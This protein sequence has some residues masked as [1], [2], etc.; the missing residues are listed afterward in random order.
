MIFKKYDK[1]EEKK[2][3]DYYSDY[4]IM[5]NKIIRKKREEKNPLINHINLNIYIEV[6]HIR[7]SIKKERKVK[8][9]EKEG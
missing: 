1:K 4:I 7:Q 9:A 2:F 5:G 6:L 8:R 3:K